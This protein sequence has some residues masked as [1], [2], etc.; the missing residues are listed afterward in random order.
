MREGLPPGTAVIG[1]TTSGEI[2]NT[3]SRRQ[4][5]VLWALGGEGIR[6]TTALV[7]GDDQGLRDHP[8]RHGGG[9]HRSGRAH[10]RGEP[11]SDRR[12]AL[13]HGHPARPPARWS[14]AGPPAAPP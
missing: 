13:R 10:H 3:G 11:R 5:L 4:A 2:A 8:E 12:T 14:T 9:R 7:Q 6:V 1:C